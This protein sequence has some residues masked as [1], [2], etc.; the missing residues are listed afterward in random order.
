MTT[1]DIFLDAI[2][3]VESSDNPEAWGDGGRAMGRYQVHPDRLW[4]EAKKW[5]VEPQ[6]GATWDAF[7]ALVLSLIFEANVEVFEP[8]EIAM[9]WHL[10]HW[11]KPGVNGWDRAYEQ[12]FND[13]LARATGRAIS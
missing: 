12:K 11:A 5:R 10:G 8:R 2:A 4:F 3:Q 13:A 9:Y 6:L 7:T 1:V